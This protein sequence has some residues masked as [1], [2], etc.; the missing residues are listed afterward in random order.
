MKNIF[1]YFSVYTRLWLPKCLGN[2]VI[3]CLYLSHKDESDMP[4]YE[5]GSEF[6]LQSELWEHDSGRSRLK[7]TRLCQCEFY[8]SVDSSVWF[9]HIWICLSLWMTA[10]NHNLSLYT[11]TSQYIFSL[12]F[13]KHIL[14][15][16]QGEFF[17]QSRASLVGEFI[18]F[19]LLTLKFDPGMMLQGNIRCYI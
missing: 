10:C 16:W 13:S 7:L 5:C 1:Y 17:K 3:L 4:E 9:L 2:N 19:I 14:R 18:S 6:S 8:E 11:Q 15:C 12:L